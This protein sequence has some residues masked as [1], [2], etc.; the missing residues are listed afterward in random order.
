[1]IASLS[2]I[3]AKVTASWSDKPCIDNI[4]IYSDDM[5]AEKPWTRTDTNWSAVVVR[6]RIY[7]SGKRYPSVDL[8]VGSRFEFKSGA[9]AALINSS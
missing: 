7:V 3:E 9:D 1:M 5:W 2:I 4:F 6:G 8:P